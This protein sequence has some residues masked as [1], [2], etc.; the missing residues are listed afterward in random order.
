MA[1]GLLLGAFPVGLWGG[2]IQC[3]CTARCSLACTAHLPLVRLPACRRAE[4]PAQPARWRG[5][6]H[7]GGSVPAGERA[8]GQVM[9]GRRWSSGPGVCEA[10][11]GRFQTCWLTGHAQTA[12][13]RCAPACAILPFLQARSWRTWT[14]SWHASRREGG[15]HRC[16]QHAAAGA[17]QTLGAQELCHFCC[18]PTGC[19]SP[20]PCLAARVA[21]I[22]AHDRRW[23]GAPEERGRMPL[24][25]GAAA[26]QQG[27]HALVLGWP[28]CCCCQP[29]P[30]LS[31][32]AR[33]STLPHLHVTSARCV[34]S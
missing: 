4:E 2:A 9:G 3:V 17:A 33:H 19:C 32:Q 14:N 25:P 12:D 31:C 16:V 30:L 22:Q 18:L 23:A 27:G 7:G 26:L 29:T 34:F 24:I 5:R 20:S 10:A 28:R 1:V 15:T 6:Y 21:G 8:Q 13:C 11:S